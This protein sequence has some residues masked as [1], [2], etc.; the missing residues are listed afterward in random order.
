MTYWTQRRIT[1]DPYGD[2][3]PQVLTFER[4]NG[5]RGPYS[6]SQARMAPQTE[7]STGAPVVAV[8]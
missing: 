1:I 7:Q 2:G 6:G 4:R 5:T 8:S 3:N